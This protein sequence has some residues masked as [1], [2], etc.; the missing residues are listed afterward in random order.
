MD[1]FFHTVLHLIEHTLVEA[2]YTIP[3]LFLAFLLLEFLEH[4]MSNKIQQTIQKSGR[5]GPILASVL[6]AVPQC[7]FSAMAAN[8][9]ATRI[10][11]LG[12]LIAVFLSTSDEMLL[13]MLSSPEFAPKGLI[14]VLIKI[15]IS[16]IIGFLVDIICRRFSE[17]KQTIHE[18][19][20]HEHCHCEKGIF[21]SALIHTL[22]ITLFIIVVQ[23]ALNCIMHTFGEDAIADFLSKGG[24]FTPIISAVVG[25]IPNCA[26]SV[27]IT[28]LFMS[29]SISL[30]SCLSGLL[31]GSGIGMLILFKANRPMKQNVLILLLSFAVG[32]VI[33][34]A[35]DLLGIMI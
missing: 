35:V 31:T 25:L 23:F 11:T 19:C 28:E 13:I 17:E 18:F 30:G 27:L 1:E 3:F 21:R 7:G 15:I 2:L 10:I 24:F 6:G 26:S 4:K 32:S 8:L 22:K 9:Y 34:I 12:T 33:G 5:F 29:N 16:A 20:E 14:I